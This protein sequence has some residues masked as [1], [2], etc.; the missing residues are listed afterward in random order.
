MSDTENGEIKAMKG[1]LASL[2]KQADGLIEKLSNA[3]PVATDIISKKVQYEQ[4]AGILESGK[5]QAEGAATELSTL[6]GIWKD[7]EIH[8]EEV[9]S[10]IDEQMAK[11][12]KLLSSATN[13]ALAKAFRTRRANLLWQKWVFGFLLLASAAGFIYFGMELATENI[14][15]LNQLLQY[16]I[17]KIPIFA[18]LILIEEFAR[19]QFAQA[20]KLEEDYAYKETLTISFDGYRKVMKEEGTIPENST[21]PSHILNKNLLDTLGERPGRLIEPETA[22]KVSTEKLIGELIAVSK[23]KIDEKSLASLLQSTIKFINWTSVKFLLIATIA[24]LIGIA[25]G[26]YVK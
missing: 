20:S 18:G 7:R 14:D 10:A 23:G 13:V 3:Q 19:R 9:Q 12:E 25:V 4:A 15:N 21:V 16:G 5:S 24:V 1:H 22:D 8:F 17:K 2:I 11:V 26:V 6:L